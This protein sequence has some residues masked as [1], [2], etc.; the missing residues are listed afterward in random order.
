M[1][2]YKENGKKDGLQ[3]YRVKVYYTDSYGNHK[4]ISKTAYGK[5]AASMLERQLSRQVA[6]QETSSSITVRQ[7]YE[8]FTATSAPEIRRTTMRGYVTNFTHH[9]LPRIGNVRLQKLN[10]KILNDWKNYVNSKPLSLITKQNI[11]AALRAALN[12]AVKMEYIPANP[13]TKVGNFKDSTYQK[14]KMKFYTPDEFKAFISAALAFRQESGYYDYYIFFVLRYYTG[15]RKGEIHALR[16]NCLDGN[17]LHIRKSIN[18]KTK[19]E[20]VETP[21]KNKSS[22]RTISLPASVLDILSEH[23]ERQQ[24]QYK[25]WNESGFICGYTRPL[26]DTA[27]ENENKKYSAMAGVKKIRIHD[28]RHSH[29]SLLINSGVNALE[30]AHRLGHSTVDQTLKTYAHLF[31]SEEEKTLSVLNNI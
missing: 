20:D 5:E 11:F 30:V 22:I 12:F 4:Q 27:V 18:Q 14:E 7:L 2:I 15:A 8:E 23:R 16:W 25:N 24:Q 3:K 13:L 19:G 10:A 1:P 28:F 9:I 31:P 29:A 6:R 26:R 17:K 21:P